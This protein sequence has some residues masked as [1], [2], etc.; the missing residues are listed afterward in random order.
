MRFAAHPLVGN[1][2]VKWRE[3]S[4]VGERSKACAEQRMV[5]DK[6]EFAVPDCHAAGEF[7]RVGEELLDV[8]EIKCNCECS[9]GENPR[10]GQEQNPLFQT[11]AAQI[12]EEESGKDRNG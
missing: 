1:I 2:I 6:G 12:A 7:R 4:G 11:A 3:I 8:A 5:P 10:S 9:D